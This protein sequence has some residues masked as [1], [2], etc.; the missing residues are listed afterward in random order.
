MAVFVFV[1]G[2]GDK[3][4]GHEIPLSPSS[5]QPGNTTLQW[6][7]ADGRRTPLRRQLSVGPAHS[8]SELMLTHFYSDVLSM[9]SGTTPSLSYDSSVPPV[10]VPILGTMPLPRGDLS[11]SCL[12]WLARPWIFFC[13]D[14]HSGGSA[15]N[16]D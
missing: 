2:D 4:L 9:L 3:G 16:R 11:I 12:F 14:S 15:T 10:P 8:K 13:W 7:P 6:C 1:W 5:S